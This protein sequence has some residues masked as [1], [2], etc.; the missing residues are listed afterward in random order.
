MGELL[1]DALRGWGLSPAQDAGDRAAPG[2]P[3]P[4]RPGG[5]PRS[6]LAAAASE[7]GLRCLAGDPREADPSSI[8]HEAGT[9]SDPRE[10][11]RATLGEGRDLPNVL[12]SFLLLGRSPG[13]CGRDVGRSFLHAWLG[14]LGIHLCC[15][16]VG[17]GTRSTGCPWMTQAGPYLTWCMAL[18]QAQQPPCASRPWPR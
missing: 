18:L 12:C 5:G 8:P 3:Q 13:R 7:G 10:V 9:A 11:G 4:P 17:R 14:T 1:E 2:S 15:G 6:S 16:C